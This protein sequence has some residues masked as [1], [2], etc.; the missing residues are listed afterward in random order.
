MDKSLEKLVCQRAEDKCEYCQMPQSLSAI[1]FEIDH[2]IARK[3]GGATNA[4]NLALSCFYCNSYKG[5]NIA[6]IDPQTGQLTRLFHPRRDH[7]SDHFAWHGPELLGQTAIGRAT[8]VTLAINHPDY[9]L[10]RKSLFAERGFH[11]G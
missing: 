9:V 7:W 11:L 6:G 4:E 1:T 2:I 5:P 8:V 3:H 10:V